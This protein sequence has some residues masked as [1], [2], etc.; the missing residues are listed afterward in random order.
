MSVLGRKW[1]ARY[2]R[3]FPAL[4][5]VGSI[6]FVFTV[7]RDATAQDT[8]PAHDNQKLF[9]MLN[10]VRAKAGLSALAS[11][12]RIDDAA[13]L[14]VVEF[15]NRKE[16][17]DQFEGEPS[18]LERLR[19]AQLPSG[20]AGEIMFE[21]TNL[22]QIPEF[23]KKA[24]IQEVLLN[25]AFSLA[26]LAEMQQGSDLF[27]VANLVR[28]L[29]S[30]APDEVERLVIDSVQ[31][32]RAHAKLTPF[33][34]VPMRRLRAAAC[35][36]AKKDSLKAAPINPY[37]DGG[38]P[39]KD[40]RNLTYT[41]LDPGILPSGVQTAGDDPKINSI[42]VGVCFGSSKNY[43]DGVYWVATILYNTQ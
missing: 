42:S 22:D 23:L 28:P 19:M 5:I 4:V 39:S 30:L 12:K 36:M 31:A 7:H 8:D 27:I 40:V 18:L 13:A 37:L 33:K 35:D 26:G 11:D 16:I 20:S 43:P 24:D 29:R 1:H 25:P 9:A 10:D 41:T 17:S 15:A 34:V 38:S 6:L 2:F 21:A 32:M 3:R 14:H